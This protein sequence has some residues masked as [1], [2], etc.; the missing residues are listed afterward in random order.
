MYLFFRRV[1]LFVILFMASFY[2]HAQGGGSAS[3]G[4]SLDYGFGKDANK[5]ASTLRFNYNIL[6]DF[7]VAPSFSYYINED[8]KKMHMFSF[9]FHYLFRDLMPDIIPVT[10]NQGLCLYPI[11]GFCVANISDTKRPCSSCSLSDYNPNTSYLSSFGFD[12]GVGV[13]YELPTLLPLLRDMSAVFEAQYH[14]LDDFGRPSFAFG[15]LY[16]F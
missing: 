11:A 10:K 8:G 16:G 7:R 3:V 14:A 15:V 12:F 13:E 4:L 5:R 2:C 1:Q 6:D 9:N